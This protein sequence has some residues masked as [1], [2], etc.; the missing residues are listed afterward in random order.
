MQLKNNADSHSEKN[1]YHVECKNY[2]DATS[3]ENL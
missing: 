3:F 2:A 1:D